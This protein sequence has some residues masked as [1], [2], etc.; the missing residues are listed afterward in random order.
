M[1]AIASIVTVIAALA[2]ICLI[3]GWALTAAISKR[4]AGLSPAMRFVLSLIVGYAGFSLLAELTTSVFGENVWTF[5]ILPPILMLAIGVLTAWPKCEGAPTGWR[6]ELSRWQLL[7]C[8][9]FS[10]LIVLQVAPISIGDKIYWGTPELDYHVRVPVTRIIARHGLPPQNPSYAPWGEQPLFYYYGYFL[11]PAALVRFLGVHAI[12]TVL[13]LT[14]VPA[15]A[16]A[17][18]CMSLANL[19][20]GRTK[21]GWI[22]LG[23]LFVTGI[24]II[25]VV[26]FHLQGRWLES[27]EWWNIGFVS[28]MTGFLAWVPHHSMATVECLVAIILLSLADNGKNARGL[29]RTAPPIMLVIAACGITSTYVGMV[30]FASLGV[31]GLI[32]AWRTESGWRSA[33]F[34]FAV[35]T[36]AGLLIIPFY[37]YLFSIDQYRGSG[38]GFFRPFA[39]EKDIAEWLGSPRVIPIY[40]VAT[41]YLQ[42]FFEFGFWW[43][44]VL[45]WV[46]KRWGLEDRRGVFYR[47][48]VM[49]G[50]ALFIGSAIVSVRSNPDLSWRVMHPLQA[51]LVP[52]GAAFA[53]AGFSIAN[54]QSRRGRTEA[55]VLLVL[56]AIGVTYDLTRTRLDYFVAFPNRPIQA[57]RAKETAA[58]LNAHTPVD[59]RIQYDFEIDENWLLY[60]DRDIPL[61]DPW[62][63]SV[64]YGINHDEHSRVKTELIEFFSD[65]PNATRRAELI[66]KYTIDFVIIERESKLF[67]LPGAALFG[68]AAKKCFGRSDCQVFDVRDLR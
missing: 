37:R 13:T 33:F 55:I 20:T 5:L 3:P 42:Y 57:A 31:Y 63:T 68:P 45:A 11:F 44:V 22:A 28:S 32:I 54:D 64:I 61:A 12:A 2:V 36:I 1:T 58:W 39:G 66:R 26:F 7:A 4:S 67:G 27:L 46:A 29:W 40:R 18:I 41:L 9:A 62:F 8:L 47:L 59:A 23:L 15:F 21:G 10:L 30:L 43:V 6:L 60:L 65:R 24:D 49:S 35:V 34:T 19:L 48:A 56:G 50:C 53:L 14:I 16:F 38:I 51:A 17:A 25:P 52:I